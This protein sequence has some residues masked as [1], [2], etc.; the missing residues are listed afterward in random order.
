MDDSSQHPNGKRRSKTIHA[1]IYAIDR[2]LGAVLHL[3]GKGQ[4]ERAM[5]RLLKIEAVLVY[6][7]SLIQGIKRKLGEDLSP[8]H[9]AEVKAFL[10]EL[11]ELPEVPEPDHG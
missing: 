10:T 8:I 5:K 7:L 2:A 1:L 6:T 3:H 9:D 11:A 4:T